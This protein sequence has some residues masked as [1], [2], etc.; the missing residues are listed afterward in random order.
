M[1]ATA[2]V[3]LGWVAGRAQSTQPDFEFVVNSPGGETTV[4]CR[5][6]CNLAWVERGVNPNAKPMPTFTFN[7]RNPEGRCSSFGIGG[8]LTR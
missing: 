3:A 1:L 6:G 7:C 5:R 8:W 2:L 4:E